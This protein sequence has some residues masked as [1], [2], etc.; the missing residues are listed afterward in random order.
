MRDHCPGVCRCTVRKAFGRRQIHER[1]GNAFDETLQHLMLHQLV[2]RTPVATRRT[3]I[4]N[5]TLVVFLDGGIVSMG[6]PSGC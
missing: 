6:E 1:V 3:D 5:E 4:S 2:Q